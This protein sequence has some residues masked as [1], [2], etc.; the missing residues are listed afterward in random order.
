MNLEK[1]KANNP[2]T[3]Q[4]Q[5]KPTTKIVGHTEAQDRQR[6]PMTVYMA[7]ALKGNGICSG[8]L[9]KH[10]R[11][12]SL[13]NFNTNKH[14][15]AFAQIVRRETMCYNLVKRENNN[16]VKHQEIRAKFSGTLQL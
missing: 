5:T 11:K 6:F 4:N 9:Y 2:F 15:L 10:Q 8:H 7:K 3:P 1:E 12:K 14:T 13:N 16:Y